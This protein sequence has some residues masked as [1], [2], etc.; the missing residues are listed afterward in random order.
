MIDWL[1]NILYYALRKRIEVKM[2]KFTEYFFVY[3]YLICLQVWLSHRKSVGTKM[4]FPRSRRKRNTLHEA[5]RPLRSGGIGVQEA[6]T[7]SSPP[8]TLRPQ[9][10][11]SRARPIFGFTNLFS[12]Y[13][14]IGIDT[15]HIGIGILSVFA[16]YFAT[17]THGF[18][19]IL[20]LINAW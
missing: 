7:P 5:W 17:K 1:V 10:T 13:R 11:Q 15:H 8:T 16:D 9:R 19:I 3:F 4:A 18:T 12:R 2:R 6:S 14:L 20:P